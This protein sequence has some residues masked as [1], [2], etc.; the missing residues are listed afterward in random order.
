[1]ELGKE[2]YKTEQTSYT[3]TNTNQ[4]ESDFSDTQEE[5]QEEDIFSNI[6]DEDIFSELDGGI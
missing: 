3:Q 5:T 6:L 1:M 4:Q 2:V